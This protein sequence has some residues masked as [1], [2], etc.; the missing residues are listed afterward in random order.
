MRYTKFYKDT[1]SD[2]LVPVEQILQEYLEQEKYLEVSFWEYIRNCC[3]KNGFL[4]SV[5]ELGY[6]ELEA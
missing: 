4:E 6:T 3:D 1:E 5:P 2:E